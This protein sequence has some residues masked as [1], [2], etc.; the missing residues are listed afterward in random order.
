MK[1]QFPKESAHTWYTVDANGKVLGRLA[2]EIAKLLRGKHKPNYAPH[3]DNGDFVIVLNASKVV[4][5]GRK[6]TQKM[7]YRHSG[8]LGGQ[9]ATTAARQLQRHPER[10]VQDAV[11][12][13]LPKTTLGRKLYKRLHV[14]ADGQHPHLAQQPL[15]LKL[16]NATR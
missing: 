3:M 12:G 15:E 11:W 5:T 6:P 13:M 14:Y 8:Y 16:D 2:S 4:L 10:L 9:T 1:T 7:Y